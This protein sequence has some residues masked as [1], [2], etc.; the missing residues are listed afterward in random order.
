MPKTVTRRLWTPLVAAFVLITLP[1]ALASAAADPK[2]DAVAETTLEA[3][4]G[5][6]AWEA[7]RYLRFNF[8]G[9]RLHHWD[10]YTGRHRLEGETR[11]GQ[12]Y[13]VLHNVHSRQG[14]VWLDGELQSGEA[15]A[16]WLERAYKAWIND[17]YWL[18]M[19]YKLRDPGVDLSYDGEEE[20]DGTVYDRLHLAFE[21]VGVTP[22]D[23]YWAYVN[24][25]TGLMDRWA[26]RLQ[27]YEEGREATHWLW[28]DWKSYGGIRLA[29][30]RRGLEDGNE[31]GLG[32]IAVFDHLDDA[33]FTSPEPP[34]GD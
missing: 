19:P 15:K 27:S 22:G 18:L 28:L 23:Q 14:Q 25:E 24:R 8:F 4:G 10:R 16:E 2:A 29:A 13:V 3:M 17:T 1:P 32:E 21:G 26:Y 20:I 12:A 30:V 5:R 11:E 31:R 34:G 6:T 9:F 33:V 7:T